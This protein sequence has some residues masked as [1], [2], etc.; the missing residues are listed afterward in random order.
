LTLDPILLPAHNPGPMT[1]SGNNT[2]LLT[3]LGEAVLIDAGVGERR[4]LADLATALEDIDARLVTVAV[5]HGHRDHAAGA[6]AI[7]EVH[8]QAA[9]VKHPWPSEDDRYPVAWRAI[10]EGDTIDVGDQ[11]LL[12]LR[13]PGHSPDHVA[14]WHEAAGALYTGD[15]V[16]AGSSVMIHASRGGDLSAYLA[17]LER[18]LILGPRVL[19]P[20]HGNRIDDPAAVLTEY[21]AHRRMRER[22]VVDALREGHGTVEAIADSIYHG[23][24]AALMPAA[25]ENVR[26][27][28]EKL[29]VDSAASSQDGRWQ[30]WTT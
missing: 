1:G 26:A 5:T 22:Q 24:D 15:L 28:L 3:S 9:F 13:T 19:Y 2:Y 20:A 16:V 11:Q 27:H 10:D 23:L 4:H 12:V 14:F 6:P 30:L 21:L 18:I 7:A 17:S 25:R 29:K 8:A